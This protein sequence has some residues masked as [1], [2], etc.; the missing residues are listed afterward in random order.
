MSICPSNDIH[1]VYLDNEL[2]AE[3]IAEYENHINNCPACQAELKKLKA[4]KKIFADDAKNS[5]PDSHYVDESFNR[6]MVKMSYSK[7]T[8]KVSRK[9]EVSFKSISYVAMAAAAVIAFAFIVPLRVTNAK[10]ATAA[11]ASV[12]ALSSMPSMSTVPGPVTSVSTYGS[13]ANNVSLNSGRSV[14]IS[15]NIDG[16]VLPPQNRREYKTDVEMFRPDFEEPATISIKIT[17]PGIE[18]GHI[19]QN[20]TL[21]EN[22]PVN[23]VFGY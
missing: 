7:H 3:F 13:R 17:I 5:T 9:P 21:P 11:A 19:P 8:R 18:N 15:G 12:A 14:V 6:L 23:V 10:K 20:L 1:S 16:A 22:I 4:L 2:P